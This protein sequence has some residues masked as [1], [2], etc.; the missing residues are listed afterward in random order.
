[1][2]NLRKHYLKLRGNLFIPS[3]ATPGNFS[4]LSCDMAFSVYGNAVMLSSPLGLGAVVTCTGAHEL[5]AE[6]VD[7]LERRSGAEVTAVDKYR[8]EVSA[9][10]TDV[11]VAFAQVIKLHYGRQQQDQCEGLRDVRRAVSV[12]YS[13]HRGDCGANALPNLTFHTDILSLHLRRGFTL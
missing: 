7:N 9:T 4:V 8:K 11:A 10:A 12:W 2:S 5:T 13:V 3:R 6:D 1:M